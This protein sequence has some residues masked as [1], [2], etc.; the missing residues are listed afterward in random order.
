M[1]ITPALVL[2]TILAI[3]GPAWAATAAPPPAGTTTTRTTVPGAVAIGTHRVF[4]LA[5]VSDLSAERRAQAARSAI[6]AAITPAP[7]NDIVKPIALPDDV[8]TRTINHLPVVTFKGKNIITVT[9]PDVALNG[10]SGNALADRWA[11]QLRDALA[12]LNITDRTAFQ[13]IRD[14][15]A[16]AGTTITTEATNPSDAKLAGAIRTRLLEDDSLRNEPI[17]VNVQNG[18]VTLKGTVRN[19][20]AEQ[21]A[22]ETTRKVDG[23]DSVRSDLRIRNR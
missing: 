6:V 11:Q 4:N 13:A 8:Q 12:G 5:P 19:R 21:R 17:G 22:V 3:G 18:V 16:V 9:Q 14:E 20:Q 23:V 10:V 1:R 7:G 15:I 2:T